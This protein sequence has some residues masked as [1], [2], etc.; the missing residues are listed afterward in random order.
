MNRKRKKKKKK[1]S[2]VTRL[3]NAVWKSRKGGQV[4]AL[5]VALRCTHMHTPAQLLPVKASPVAPPNTPQPAGDPFIPP[6]LQALLAGTQRFTSWHTWAEV[7]VLPTHALGSALLSLTVAG[8]DRLATLFPQNSRVRSWRLRAWCRHVLG[9]NQSLPFP[10]GT[11]MSPSPVQL[12]Q[13][14][15]WTPPVH[16]APL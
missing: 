11:P 16:S 15:C 2:R 4:L 10:G 3:I 7:R 12:P 6:S 13:G 5:S 1:H 8:R 14:C 9:T